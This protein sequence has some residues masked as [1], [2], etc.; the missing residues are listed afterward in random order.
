MQKPNALVFGYGN[1]SRG[2]DALGPLALEQLASLDFADV[3]LLGDFQ[4]QIEHALDLENRT[5]VLF[6]DANASCAA[7]FEFCRLQPARD[8]SYTTHA[9]SPEAVLQVYR[10]LNDREPPPCFLLGI[11]GER[12]E[13]GEPLSETAAANL[14]AAMEFLES[15]CSRLELEYWR[16]CLPNNGPTR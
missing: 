9:M 8:R 6:V 14:V 13:L 7:P 3:E 5:L 11:R 15:L 12:F 1:P 4:L 2:D 16:N 10:E